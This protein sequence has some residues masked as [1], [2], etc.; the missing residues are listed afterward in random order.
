VSVSGSIRPE[1]A[2]LAIDTATEAPGVALHVHDRTLVRPIGWRA[3]FRETGPAAS[4]L[5]EAAG[6]TLDALAALVVPAGPGSFTGLRVGASMALGLARARTIPLHAVPT[7]EAVAAAYASPQAERVCAVLDAR[8]GRWYA[9]LVERDPR[10]WR[11]GEPQDLLP[12][13]ARAL[14][15]SAPLVGAPV[16][17]EPAGPAPVASAL[18]E[19]VITAPERYRL[20]KPADLRLAYARTGVEP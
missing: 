16:A 12:A 20:G 8:R 15:G 1:Q 7:L 2:V 5:L 19:L 10:G 4:S 18:L 3:S 11:A 14:A 13:A 6:T 9:A 17:T